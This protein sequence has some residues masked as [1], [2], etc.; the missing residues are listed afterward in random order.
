MAPEGSTRVLA[1]ELPHLHHVFL[2]HVVGAATR[3]VNIKAMAR[4]ESRTAMTAS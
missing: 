2:S 1:P 4:D 3:T